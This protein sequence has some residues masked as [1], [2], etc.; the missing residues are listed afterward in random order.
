LKRTIVSL[1]IAG[2]NSIRSIENN[3][4]IIYPGISCSFG[5]IQAL[6]IESQ[7]RCIFLWILITC[8]HRS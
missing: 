3:I 8:S 1:S 7:T 5:Y 2:V 6:Q 4:P